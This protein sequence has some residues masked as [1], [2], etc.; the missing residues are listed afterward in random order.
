MSKLKIFGG[1]QA[2]LLSTLLLAACGETATQVLSHTNPTTDTTN[3]ITP[4]IVAATTLLATATTQNSATTT[5]VTF[6]TT[7]VIATTLSQASAPT[8]AATLLP[9]ASSSS[10]TINQPKTSPTSQITA[11]QPSQTTAPTPAINSN[12][13]LFTLHIIGGLCIYGDCISDITVN[14]DGSFLDKDGGGGQKSGVLD[15]KRVD[16]L[17][18]EIDR[19]DFNAIKSRKF[20]G[21]CPTAYDGQEFIYTFYLAN[22]Q[23]RISSCQYALD[24][25]SPLFVKIQQILELFK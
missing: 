19:T 4:S 9:K 17:V 8:F 21:T 10:T 5:P 7:T 20:V 3:P 23:E 12:K 1:F 2:C 13:P 14:R 24:S 15:K 25:N 18:T 6:V 11:T 22:S 16:E